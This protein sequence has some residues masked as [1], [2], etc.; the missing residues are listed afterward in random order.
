MELL[1]SILT[2]DILPI[3]AI[4]AAG[5]LLARYAGAI[6]ARRAALDIRSARKARK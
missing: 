6:S 3:F 5:F 2:S 1:L 4:A